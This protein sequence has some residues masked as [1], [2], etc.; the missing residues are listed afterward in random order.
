MATGPG[1]AG[2]SSPLTYTD[3]I[4]AGTSCTLMWVSSR[5]TSATPTVSA[6]VGVTA[7]TLMA[8][9]ASGSA[10][11]YDFLYCFALLSPPTGS[12]TINFT[13]ST[14]S[15][16][17][18]VN[19]CHY[20]NVSSIGTASVSANGSGQPFMSVAPTATTGIYASGFMFLPTANGQTFSSYN[21]NQRYVIASSASNQPLIFGDAQGNGATLPF[22]A[23]RSDTTYQW[24]GIIVPL[25]RT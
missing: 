4:P 17:L 1:S 12:Q 24:G 3:T 15:P 22:S 18:V 23:T 5:G 13:T 20:A 10:G 8:S 25:L 6:S 2:T 19:T 14:G 9:A 21:Q 11:A 16:K 7:A